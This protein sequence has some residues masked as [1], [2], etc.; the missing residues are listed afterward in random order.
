MGYRADIKIRMD[1]GLRS[2][3][4]AAAAN[5]GVSMNSE[6]VERLKKS[7]ADDVIAARLDRIEALLIDPNC[8]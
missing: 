8:R 5:H 7:F 3:I 2:S 6:M 1:E 4:E